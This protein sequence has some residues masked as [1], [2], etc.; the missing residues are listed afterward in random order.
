MPAALNAAAA[1]G[2]IPSTLVKS[3]PPADFFAFVGAAFL[4][5]GFFSAAA[6]GI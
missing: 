4:A 3:S 6:L 1:L 2:P 5:A